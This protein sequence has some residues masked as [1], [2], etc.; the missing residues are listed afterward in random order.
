MIELWFI[1]CYYGLLRD[2]RVIDR[3]ICNQGVGVILNPVED[4]YGGP[5]D[6]LSGKFHSDAAVES[7]HITI[8]TSHPSNGCVCQAQSDNRLVE[9]D[10]RRLVIVKRTAP[11]TCDSFAGWLLDDRGPLCS[12]S[13]RWVD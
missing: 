7:V 3:T 4:S 12:A 13:N 5:E 10:L 1:L 9:H 2:T 6:E 11:P 8:C